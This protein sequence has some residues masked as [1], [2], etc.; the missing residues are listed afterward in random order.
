M[1]IDR[2]TV[3]ADRLMDQVPPPVLEG[4]NGGVSIRRRAMR[5]PT[6]PE[7]VYILGEYITD[8]AMGCYVILYYGSFA[9]IFNGQLE[10]AWEAQLWETIRH[11][12]RHHLEHR[13]GEHDLDVEDAVQLADMHRNLPPAPPPEPARKYRLNRPIRGRES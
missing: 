6:D 3:L 12:L 4:L 1:D 8:A 11:E 2:F 9:A 10:E 13:A 7:G 5:R